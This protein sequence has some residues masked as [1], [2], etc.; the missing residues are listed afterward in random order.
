MRKRLKALWSWFLAFLKDYLPWT[1][2]DQFLDSAWG[3][4]FLAFLGGAIVT[5]AGWLL[6]FFAHLSSGWT[7]GF[8][9]AFLA[10]TAVA[11]L[12]LLFSPASPKQKQAKSR[13][14]SGELGFVDSMVNMEAAQ[15]TFL[16]VLD[17]IARTQNDLTARIQKH[18]AAMEK[19]KRSGRNVFFRMRKEAQ[20]AALSTTIAVSEYDEHIP[21]LAESVSFYF[22]GQ[23]LILDRTNPTNQQARDQLEALRQA[24]ISLRKNTVVNR[25]AQKGYVA[26]LN[27]NKG[28]SQDLNLA[29]D[30]MIERVNRTTVVLDDVEARSS[31]MLTVINSKLTGAAAP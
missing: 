24:I 9:G 27:N 25:D 13:Y 14:I 3:R 8:L 21:E 28:F 17:K 31:A 11:V 26:A 29:L 22:D 20:K 23:L 5:G 6:S 1:G 4:R 19:I 12:I 15:K 10:T 18:T 30:Q 16:K 2:T 7:Y